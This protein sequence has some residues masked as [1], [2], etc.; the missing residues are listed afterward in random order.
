MNNLKS[1]DVDKNGLMVCIN[2]L[3]TNDSS[4]WFDSRTARLCFRGIAT[5]K[6]TSVM[7]TFN[8]SV[9][10]LAI[11]EKWNADRFRDLKKRKSGPA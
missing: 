8:D 2:L 5:N 7:E 9:Q 10:L 3:S 4:D 1:A 6:E 11:L